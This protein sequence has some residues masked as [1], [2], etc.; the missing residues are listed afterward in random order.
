MRLSRVQGGGS[1]EVEPDQLQFS[2]DRAG[3]PA[4]RA[5]GGRRPSSD[6]PTKLPPE[7]KSGV[8]G[9]TEQTRY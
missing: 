4:E 8:A 5:P 3:I 1:T 2:W 7:K 9:F 6:R